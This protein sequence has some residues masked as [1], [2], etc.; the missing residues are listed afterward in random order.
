M[1]SDQIKIAHRP[2]YKKLYFQ[3]VVAMLIGVALG[4]YYPDLAQ[5]M[6]PF[7]DGFVKL[8]KMV[9]A[10][11]IFTTVAVGIAKMGSLK[12]IGRVGFRSLIYF[13]VVSTLALIVGLVVVNL[14]Q[15]GSG[16]N[17]DPKTLDAKSVSGFVTSAKT[18]TFTDFVMN[19]IP[20]SVV[21]AFAKGDLLPVLLFSVLFG[22]AL[23]HG[24]E[25]GKRVV[26]LL[27]D[28]SH[29]LFGVV[30]IIMK[31]APIG[32]FGAMAFTV[33]RYGLGTLVQLSQL[34]VS[35]YLTCIV[36]VVVVLGLIS[37]IAGFNIFKF[38]RYL[39]EELL[40]VFGA[41]SAEAM[42][43]RTMGKLV[44]MGVSKDIVGLVIPTGFSFNMDGTAI[45]MTM[46]VMFI[47]QAC[48]IEL[49]LV[50]QLSILGL[51][52]FT[53]KGSAGITGGGFLALAA[54]M[55]AIDVLP[56]GGLALL[57]GIDRFMSE[58]RAVTNLFGNAVATVVIASW[59]N[60]ID[61][62]QAKR[63]L[64]QGTDEGAN[65]EKVHDATLGQPVVA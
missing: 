17:A 4:F 3:V 31:V 35:V 42:I 1:E 45:Y 58:I 21:D 47:A 60:A 24:G 36:F 20:S 40:V 14:I 48:N 32:A 44:N 56:I 38:A 49:S 10:P 39:R 37:G 34:I 41:T 57:I 5:L 52:L 11:I 15:P 26:N 61:W 25:T 7:G 23:C 54:T 22:F 62:K 64:N 30:G 51:M 13:E 27:D 8:I 2:L 53:S 59:E 46:G 18:T 19:I 55:P 9:I 50:Q 33:G 28:F 29:A 12:K 43:P 16:I 65:P 6:K 63:I